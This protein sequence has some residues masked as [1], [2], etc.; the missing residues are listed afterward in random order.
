MMR[1][2]I[3]WRKFHK[4]S[5]MLMAIFILM[6]C[7]SGMVLNHR[8]LFADCN[9]S[10][11]FLPKSYRLNQ[12]NNGV[13]KGTIALSSDSV[14]AYGN[15]GLWL[16]NREFENF[17]DFNQGFPAGIDSR[18]IKNVVKA[19]DGSLW[20]AAQFGVYRYD[21]CQWHQVAVEGNA[22][23]FSDI[24]LGPDSSTLIVLSRSRIFTLNPSTLK[25]ES[26]IVASPQGEKPKVTLFKTFWTLHS[27]ELFGV[28]GRIVVDIVAVILIFLSITGII[29]FFLPYK[30]KWTARKRETNRGDVT[31]RFFKWNLHLHDKIGYA[32]AILTI[33]IAFT[34]MCLRPPLMIPLVMTKTSPLPGSTLDSH[35]FW[36]DKMRGI[37]WDDDLGKW[38]V[39]TSEGF[40]YV[41]A[42]FSGLPIRIANDNTPPVSPMGITVFENA[43]PGRWVIGSFSGLFLWDRIAGVTTDVLSGER[44]N[45][46]RRV[47]GAG[48]DLISGISR[49]TSGGDMIIF[50]YSSG[51]DKL[52][53]MKGDIL[54]QPMSLWNAALELHVGRCYAPFLGPFSQLFVFIFGLLLTLILISGVIVH[55]SRNRH[56]RH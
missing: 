45:P 6:F 15:T 7:I 3:T 37:R 2:K 1:R 39:S 19:P 16:T 22:E 25:I 40:I 44:Y 47:Y 51:N 27:G 12:Y 32:T 4:W 14:L 41:D 11:Q 29:V 17:E 13:I 20:C 50:D 42:D 53:Q 26:H 55:M 21:G 34:G 56:G 36:H 46:A 28:A 43:G 54:N 35:N 9:I 52:P 23:R 10:R 30:F 5:G 49:D 48:S 33:V 18:N 24:V 38:L 8:E 31:L